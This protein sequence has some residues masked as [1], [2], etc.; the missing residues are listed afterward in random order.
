MPERQGISRPWRCSDSRRRSKPTAL[1]L[2][3]LVATLT[4]IVF[5][6]AGL[7]DW[8]SLWPFLLGSV[9]LAFAGGAIRLPGTAYRIIVGLILIVSAVR[10]MWGSGDGVARAGYAPVPVAA[11]CGG[12]IGLLSGLTGTGGTRIA[13]GTPG[14]TSAS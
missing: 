14:G 1:V 11:V 2:N 5:Y 8:R 13:W 3:V 4:A 12:G 9:P 10:L 6:R 7:L